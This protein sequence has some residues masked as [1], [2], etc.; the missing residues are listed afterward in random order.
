MWVDLTYAGIKEATNKEYRAFK[1]LVISEHMKLYTKLI[2]LTDVALK[3]GIQKS[4][5]GFGRDTDQL[6][7]P[8]KDK[9]EVVDD[10]VLKDFGTSGEHEEPDDSSEA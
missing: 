4:Q 9:M 8:L 1:R 5:L 7:D 10:A 2:S 6:P 3:L